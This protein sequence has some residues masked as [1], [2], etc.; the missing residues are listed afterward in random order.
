[1]SDTTQA[2]R[3]SY[4][5][6]TFGDARQC[7]ACG[8]TEK[9]SGGYTHSK[10]TKLTPSENEGWTHLVARRCKCANCGTPRIDYFREVRKDDDDKTTP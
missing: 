6:Q 5:L 3:E 2:T 4:N 1:M 9:R 10:T 7:P 8:S